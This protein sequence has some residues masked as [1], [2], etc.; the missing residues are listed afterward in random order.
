MK[1]RISISAPVFILL[2]LSGCNVIERD[3]SGQT[4]GVTI[5]GPARST[6][7]EALAAREIRRYLYLRTGHL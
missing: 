1:R 7:P 4:Q 5:I 3:A 6:G 2:A